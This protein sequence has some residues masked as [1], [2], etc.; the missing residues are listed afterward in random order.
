MAIRIMF[1]PCLANLAEQPWSF[2]SDTEA[3]RLVRS[4]RGIDLAI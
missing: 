2:T 1:S 4:R 3:R